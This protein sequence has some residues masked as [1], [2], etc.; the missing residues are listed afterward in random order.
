MTRHF[1]PPPWLS[2]SPQP[3]LSIGDRLDVVRYEESFGDFTA[4]AWHHAGEPQKFQSNWHI[5]CIV[6]HLTAVARREIK[7]P[8]PLIFTM[9]PRHMKSRGVNVF[10]PAWVWAQDPDPTNAGHGLMVRPGTLMGPGVKF[11]HLSYVQELSDEHSKGCRTLIDSDWYQ[12]RWGKRCSL[13]RHAVKHLSN[14]SGGERRA[15]TFRSVTGFGADIIV[16]DDAHDIKLVDSAVIRAEV[17]KTWD[18]VLQTRLNDPAIGIFIVIM[19]RSHERDLVGH[20]L[21][22]EFNGMHI[23]LPAEFGRDHP[24]VFVNSRW[25]VPRRTDSEQRHRGRT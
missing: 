8:G 10:F 17:L 11:A 7:G 6:D 1:A 23:C 12:A 24:Y 20:I 9:P 2:V 13:Y 25:P 21:A 18:E 15:M 19:Q 14:S 22:K 3:L 4:A 16:I 5:D